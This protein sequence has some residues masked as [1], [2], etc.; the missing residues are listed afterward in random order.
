M[1]YTPFHGLVLTSSIKIG[2]YGPKDAFCWKSVCDTNVFGCAVVCSHAKFMICANIADR[3]DNDVKK[4]EKK[5]CQ[6]KHTCP[7]QVDNGY[8][9][10]KNN[11][12]LSQLQSLGSAN[13]ITMCEQ[14]WRDR[15][16][17][18]LCYDN[19]ANHIGNNK[20]IVKINFNNNKITALLIKIKWKVSCMMITIIFFSRRKNNKDLI[21]INK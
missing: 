20:I 4:K 5:G 16:N 8:Q 19:D 7:N 9:S 21:I 18:T 17:D 2:F 1:M 14:R 6:Y 13:I 10:N 15:N 12:C 3:N 11:P